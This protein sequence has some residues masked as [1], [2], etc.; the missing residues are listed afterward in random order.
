MYKYTYIPITNMM[1]FDMCLHVVSVNVNFMF[2]SNIHV[3]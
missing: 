1:N 3:N 2:T